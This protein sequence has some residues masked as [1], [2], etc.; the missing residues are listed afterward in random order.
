MVMDQTDDFFCILLL[1]NGKVFVCD[2]LIS[3][4]PQQYEIYLEVPSQG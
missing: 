2:H 1:L 3:V 4:P